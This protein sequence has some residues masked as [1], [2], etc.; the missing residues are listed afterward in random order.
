MLNPYLP[1]EI[2]DHIVGFLHDKPEALKACCL[3]SKLWVP[4]TRIHLSANIESNSA[5]DLESWGETFPDITNSLACQ[6]RT[7]FVGC[8]QFVVAT[9]AEEG[10]WIRAFSRVERLNLDNGD[11]CVEFSGSP[12]VGWLL[13]AALSPSARFCLASDI[14]SWPGRSGELQGAATT[15]AKGAPSV[16]RPQ[17]AKIIPH[18]GFVSCWRTF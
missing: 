9:D 2:L 7:L 5:S 3:A 15:V 12:F 1:Q 17:E 13:L 8:S 10:G 16:S 14:S 11:Q 18:I 6:T 4:R